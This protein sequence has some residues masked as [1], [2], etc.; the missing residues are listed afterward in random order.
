[1]DLRTER[2]LR[3]F[4]VG[5]GH[6][7]P[8]FKP[9]KLIFWIRLGASTFFSISF[10]F[11]ASMQPYIAPL[12]FAV[13][14]P[15]YVIFVSFGCWRIRAIEKALAKAEAEKRL[16]H[17]SQ[18]GQQLECQ[19]REQYEQ[20]EEYQSELMT[21]KF[22]MALS[23]GSACLAISIFYEAMPRLLRVLMVPLVLFL[24]WYSCRRIDR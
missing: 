5:V 22:E 21:R 1:M 13:L 8:D 3:K 15:T 20:S 2:I 14:V 24:A 6:H 9:P 18:S 7:H 23:L 17:T 12:T 16:S 10:Y 11:L 19:T 4:I